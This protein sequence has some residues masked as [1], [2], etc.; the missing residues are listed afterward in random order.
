MRGE[1]GEERI[2]TGLRLLDSRIGGGLG[3]G[4]LGMITACT[5]VGKTT[6]L[7]NFAYG[8][9]LAGY[10]PLL[11]TLEMSAD[12]IKRRFASILS[13][14]NAMWIKRSVHDW[15]EDVVN[16]FQA[17][18]QTIETLMFCV[19]DLSIA[20][21]ESRTTLEYIEKVIV[22]WQ[23]DMDKRGYT[24]RAWWVG[25]DYLDKIVPPATKRL[26]K[27][28]RTDELQR[29]L[30]EQMSD[31]TRKLNITTW[32]CTQGNKEG[33]GKALVELRHTG[34]SYAKNAPLTVGLGL[35]RKN[36]AVD[37]LKTGGLGPSEYE[38]YTDEFSGVGE[39][40]VCHI[41]KNRD[42]PV[43][44]C[45]VYRGPTL[46]FWDRI[47]DAELEQAVLSRGNGTKISDWHN[48]VNSIPVSKRDEKL[49][50]LFATHN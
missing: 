22:N 29:I 26:G 1:E 34:S 17:A 14:I 35:G 28:T 18:I 25:I 12:K 31:M 42:N 46:K 48:L 19:A 33:D 43:G 21:N 7:I 20:G 24:K 44:I 40:L 3:R 6:G 36:S 9:L 30:S 38:E 8:A 27:N 11:V 23:E 41:G 39:E 32:T 49:A 45:S 37:K 13:G 5:G 4:E 47:Q 2:P 50:A 16:R 15:P 10:F